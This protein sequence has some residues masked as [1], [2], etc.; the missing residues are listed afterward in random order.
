MNGYLK[1][2]HGLDGVKTVIDHYDAWSDTYDTEIAENG[3]ALPKRMAEAVASVMDDKSLPL[4]D[5]G[6]GTGLAGAA[7]KSL[8]FTTIDGMDVSAEMMAQAAPKGI[9]RTLTHIDPGTALPVPAGTYPL[10]TACGVIGA[11]A[12]P[13]DVLDTL[14]TS[15]TTGGKLAFSFNDKTLLDPAYLARVESHQNNGF[16]LIYKERGAHLPGIDMKSTVYIL[17]KT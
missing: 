17:E 10:I 12:A 1:Q 8:G 9:Y 7:L 16:D 4:L 6:C 13:L 14:A 2:V 15:L 3:Y 5:F 11:G